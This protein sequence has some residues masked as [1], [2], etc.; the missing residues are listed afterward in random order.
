MTYGELIEH[1]RRLHVLASSR[2]G[3]HNDLVQLRD[4]VPRLIE[5]VRELSEDDQDEKGF[6]P[7]SE[8]G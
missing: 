6:T 7:P 1:A 5:A 2:A 3:T 8:P 4:L